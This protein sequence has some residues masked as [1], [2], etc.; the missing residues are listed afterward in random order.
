MG[1]DTSS[2]KDTSG[3]MGASRPPQIAILGEFDPEFPPHAATN[4]AILHSSQ[5][6]RA[7]VRGVWLS[8]QDIHLDLVKEYA[9]MWVA[10]GS[11]YK[12][13]EKTLSAIRYARENLLPCFGTCGGFQHIV[14]EYAR[15]V[16]GFK[17]AHHAEYDPYASN[18]FISS[19]ARSLVG[20]EMSLTL[21]PGV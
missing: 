9:G 14:I 11:P 21:V 18:L 4:A 19:L 6:L 15:N 1:P 12:D 10:P 2:A 7:E 13:L 20:R 8:T 3:T 5:H 16:L 17:D